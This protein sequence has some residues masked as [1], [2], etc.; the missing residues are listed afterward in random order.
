MQEYE[1]R[2]AD[3]ESETDRLSQALEAQKFAT[4]AAQAAASKRVE[5]LGREVQKKAAEV[6][7]LKTKLKQYSDYDEIKRELEIMKVSYVISASTW[8]VLNAVSQEVEFAGLEGDDDAEDDATLNGDALG[9]HLPD[10]NVAKVD[11]Q[12]SKSLE[13]LLATKNKRI[14]EELTKFRVRLSSLPFA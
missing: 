6:D 2:I 10:T 12:R 11:G 14:L 5:E 8:I 3:L 1:I 4:E 13:F 7:Q 9:L